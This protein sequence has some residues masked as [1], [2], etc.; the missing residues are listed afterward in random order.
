MPQLRDPNFHRMVVLM[1]EH[2][3]E[4]S[5]GVVVNN[6]C[7]ASVTIQS[8][9]G[10]SLSVG[11]NVFIGGPVSPHVCMVVHGSGWRC[12]RTKEVVEGLCISEPSASMPH[13]LEQTEVPYRFIMGYAG[14]GPGQL[15]SEMTKGAWLT[16][17]V[18]ANLVIDEEPEKQWEAV[19]SNL[20][21]DPMM[22]IPATTL[23]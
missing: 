2:N 8:N 16:S 6:P 23:Q 13:L 1:L 21:I 22:L 19:I 3:E 9:E 7:S 14:W 15:S 17:P 4:G 11:R 5:F 18:R 10:D 20:G 12:E